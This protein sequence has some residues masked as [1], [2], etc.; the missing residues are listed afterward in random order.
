MYRR[1]RG[2][3]AAIVALAC[4]LGVLAGTTSSDAATGA[5]AAAAAPAF[6]DGVVLVGFQP[7]TPSARIADALGAVTA[8]STEVI[9]AGTQVVTVP[10]GEVATAIA[11]LRARPEVRYAEPNYIAHATITPNDPSYSQLYGMAK[12]GAPAAWDTSTGDGSVVV[13]VLDTGIDGTHPDLAANMW[14]NPGTL[15]G[16]AANTTGYDAI[17]SDCSPADDHYHGTHVSGTIGAAGNNGIGVAGV[18]WN[19]KLMGLK[20]L[21]SG[22]SGSYEA[23]ISGIDH[24]VAAKQAGVNLRVL[25]A[26]LGGS[27]AST[28]LQDAM[29]RATAAGIIFVAAA[30]NSTANVDASPV[31]PCVYATV[32]VAAT[33]SNDARASFSNYGTAN[34][35]IAAPGVATLSTQPGGLYQS[36]SGT[37]MA[38]PHVSG[39]LA[40]L[41]ESGQCRTWSASALTA[42]VFSSSDTIAGLGIAGN[43]RLNVGKAM[44]TCND[45]TSF[46]VSATPADATVNAGSSVTSTISTTPTTPAQTVTLS[47]SGLPAGATASFKP[48]IGDDRCQLDTHD[49]DNCSNRVRA[50]PPSPSRGRGRERRRAPRRSR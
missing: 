7:G 33:D 13:G 15:F 46:V 2:L 26:S 29:N 12:I 42:L 37:S 32:C 47:A 30:G 6:E 41:A 28:A 3:G 48:G 16:C 50:R 4:G 18:S 10:A 19:V 21:D 14:K 1:G 35:D 43:R 23:I 36:L 22:G 38:T 9:G 44:A 17:N 49:R 40:L 45:P 34:V 8:T 27:G 25:S 24:A 20:V 5:A 31:Y 11:E 39:A